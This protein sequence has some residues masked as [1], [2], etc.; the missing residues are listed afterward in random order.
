MRRLFIL[1]A[2]WAT[3]SA[4]QDTLPVETTPRFLATTSTT[5]TSLRL[6]IKL[7][8]NAPNRV[9]PLRANVFCGGVA[10]TLDQNKDGTITGGTPVTPASL[11]APAAA[12]TTATTVLAGATITDGS[13]LPSL[14]VPATQEFPI[15]I[16]DVLMPAGQ[17]AVQSYTFTLTAGSSA[18]LRIS[19]IWAQK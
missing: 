17:S 11:T 8:A 9:Y 12:P 2:A 14:S 5:G 7:A 16:K 4:Q 3:L 1:F 18:T 10:C 6:T 13:T 15:E 19:V